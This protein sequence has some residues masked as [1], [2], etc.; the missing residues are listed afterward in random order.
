MIMHVM[1]DILNYE[2]IISLPGMMRE[3]DAEVEVIY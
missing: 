2:V 3:G 1:G